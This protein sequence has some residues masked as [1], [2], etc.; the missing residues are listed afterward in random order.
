MTINK[1]ITVIGWIV[2]ALLLIEITVAA[3]IK[4]REGDLVSGVNYYGQPVG[5]TLQLLIVAIT[6]ALLLFAGLRFVWRNRKRF[7]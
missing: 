4:I 5:T 1:G 7:R 2:A 3:I 6:V